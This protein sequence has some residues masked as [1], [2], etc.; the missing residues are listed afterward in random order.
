YGSFTT[1]QGARHRVQIDGLVALFQYY[2]LLALLRA[3][4]RRHALAPVEVPWDREDMGTMD[5]ARDADGRAN[6]G[7]AEP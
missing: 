2:G 4:F 1:L 6:A 5:P 7:H 3:R